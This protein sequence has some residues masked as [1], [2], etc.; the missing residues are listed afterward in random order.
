MH[1]EAPVIQ[2]YSVLLNRNPKAVS[3]TVSSSKIAPLA[4]STAGHTLIMP[5][6][7][8]LQNLSLLGPSPIAGFSLYISLCSPVP[9]KMNF[10]LVPSPC[11]PSLE[12]IYKK[13]SHQGSQTMRK[14]PFIYISTK[15]SKLYPRNMSLAL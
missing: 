15:M 3:R 11:S 1:Y 2:F 8:L 7:L 14:L 5:A 10:G 9:K 12:S 13:R 4:L 6:A